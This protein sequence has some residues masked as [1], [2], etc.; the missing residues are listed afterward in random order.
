MEIRE[1]LDIVKRWW[2]LA[3]LSVAVAATSSYLASRSTTPL[4]RTTTTLMVGRVT[5][6]RDPNQADFSISQQ[7]ATTYAQ[8]ATRRNVLE[9][10]IDSLG[11]QIDWAALAGRV[12]AGTVGRTQ[13]LEISVVDSNP[14]RAKA[15]ADAIAEQLI[16]LSPTTPSG[17]TQEEQA[18]VRQQ[19]DDLRNNIEEAEREIELLEEE[20]DAAISARQIQDLE[21]QIQLLEGKVTDWQ[22]TYSQLLTSLQ[23]GEINVLTILEEA[24]VPGRPFSPNVRMNVLLASALGLTLAVAG[25][26]LIEFLDDTV[27]SSDDVARA[28]DLPTLGTIGRF[29]RDDYPHNLVAV[30]VPLSPIAEDYRHLGTNLRFASWDRPIR[31]LLVTSP[32]PKEG[33][34][35][36]LANLAVVMAQNGLKVVAVDTDLRRP[37]LQ[38]TFEI[39]NDLGLSS[40]IAEAA[41]AR[42]KKAEIETEDRSSS[43]ASPDGTDDDPAES[44]AWLKDYLQTTDV[45]DLWVLPSGPPPPNPA[46]L[47]G[48]EHTHQL[49]DQLAWADVMLFDSPPALAASDAAVLATRVDGVLIVCDA[50]VTRRAAVKETAER[51]RQVQANLVGVVLNRLPGRSNSYH[52]RDYYSSENGQQSQNRLEQYREWLAE[53]LR[54]RTDNGDQ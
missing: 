37:S 53:R 22:G 4:Y 41:D 35:T 38:K 14:R 10:A 33:K 24:P 28:V 26:I 44:D 25:V 47:L 1:Y 40:A 19:V 51:L 39:S 50:G 27:K 9:S 15:L 2:W 18:F 16:L 6:E 11:L 54:F 45:K 32:T 49:L 7:L 31:K 48:S 42:V 36:T 21:N 34:S 12:H 52:Y 13:L 29:N 5:Q 3:I 20:L 17:I 43:L 8:M 30:H 23:G 46:Q